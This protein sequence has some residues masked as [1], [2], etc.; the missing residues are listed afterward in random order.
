MD[1]EPIN[2]KRA[3]RETDMQY[4]LKIGDQDFAV[5]V[6]AQQAG[7]LRVTVNGTPYDVT[8]VQDAPA[9]APRV[10]SAAPPR[11]SV[12]QRPSAAVSPG[13]KPAETAAGG[14]VLAPIPGLILEI[15]VKVGDMVQAGQSVVV[16]EAMKMENNLTTGISGVVKEI[17]VQKGSEVATG[18]VILRIG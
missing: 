8:L 15:K 11:E 3:Q 6:G 7:R 4:Q 17:R 12:S 18:D 13:N 1:G 9:S 2:Q 5:E 16:M 10:A 14:T